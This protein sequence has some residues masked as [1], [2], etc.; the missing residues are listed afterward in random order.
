M[1][2]VY[3]KLIWNISRNL[4]D[5]RAEW[6]G[7]WIDTSVSIQ[8]ENIRYVEQRFY[9]R[10]KL[11]ERNNNNNTSIHPQYGQILRI[12]HIL[13]YCQLVWIEHIFLLRIE[14]ASTPTRTHRHCNNNNNHHNKRN[15]SKKRYENIVTNNST[16]GK[17]RNIVWSSSVK[18]SWIHCCCH[19]LQK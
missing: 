5:L 8:Y 6:C 4:V 19:D 18:C 14:T 7:T 11:I 12:S 3:L 13:I 10:K 9:R 2:S 15:N 17:K 1:R 16:F